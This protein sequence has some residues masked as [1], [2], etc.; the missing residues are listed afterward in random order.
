MIQNDLLVLHYSKFS[1]SFQDI[2]NAIGKMIFPRTGVG[3]HFYYLMITVFW[4]HLAVLKT[5]M[6]PAL[7][8]W[9]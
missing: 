4:N 9:I 7:A 1:F 6:M 5:K 2:I 3:D 8:A